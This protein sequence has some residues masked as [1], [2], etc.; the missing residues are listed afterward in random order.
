MQNA[1]SKSEQFSCS[2][3]YRASFPES[4]HNND[5]IKANCKEGIASL[6]ILR[7]TPFHSPFTH[8]FQYT[9]H[10]SLELDGPIPSPLLSLPT[11]FRRHDPDALFVTGAYHPLRLPPLVIT[12]VGHVQYVA[13]VEGKAARRKAVIF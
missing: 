1:L 11:P 12:G 10:V 2:K 13:V 3:Y 5:D 7:S 4:F 9:G 8:L 6:Y